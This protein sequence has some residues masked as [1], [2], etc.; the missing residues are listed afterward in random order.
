MAIFW[1]FILY[2][3]NFWC[4]TESSELEGIGSLLWKICKPY[5]LSRI[6]RILSPKNRGY[7]SRK[8]RSVEKTPFFEVFRKAL[9]DRWLHDYLSVIGR[10]TKYEFAR[11]K[12]SLRER[13]CFVVWKVMF[14]TM[15]HGLWRGQSLCF[16]LRKLTF[17]KM[18]NK[19]WRVKNRFLQILTSLSSLFPDNF[20]SGIFIS[21]PFAF[22]IK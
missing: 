2:V 13:P 6:I 16:A 9:S 17:H 20:L 3:N 15:K 10:F 11:G 18:K 14:E 4:F 19:E 7:W 22:Q 21:I 5:T 8:C 12:V 1:R